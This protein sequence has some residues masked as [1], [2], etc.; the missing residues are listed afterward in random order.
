MCSKNIP[1][2]RDIFTTGHGGYSHE[3]IV[4]A[5]VCKGPMKDWACGYFLEYERGPGDSIPA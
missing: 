1:S 4:G 2:L 3:P 5:I